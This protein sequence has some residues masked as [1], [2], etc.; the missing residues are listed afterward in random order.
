MDRGISGGYT[1]DKP[2]SKNSWRECMA[3]CDVDK[4][5]KGWTYNPSS[6]MCAKK[7]KLEV[8]YQK[9][10]LSGPVEGGV[11]VK[12][13][14]CSEKSLAEFKYKCDHT[15]HDKHNLGPPT[16]KTTWS[17]CRSGCNGDAECKAYTYTASGM[18]QKKKLNEYV[19]AKGSNQIAGPRSGPLA[20][21][22]VPSDTTATTTDKPTDKPTD[23]PA[24]TQAPTEDF[25]TKKSPLGV[26]WWVVLVVIL[27]LVIGCGG[28]MMVLVMST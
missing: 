15:I 22:I 3:A 16:F 5:C 9:G 14:D 26:P 21:E 19:E 20:G 1:I 23:A 12:P 18:C 7:K 6:K 11:E 24:T 17:E 13:Y 27:V 8:T 4:N 28:L 2:F 25:L 10:L